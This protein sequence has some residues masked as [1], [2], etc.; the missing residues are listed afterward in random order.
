M[1]RLGVAAA[2]A[3]A[4]AAPL[5]A[6]QRLTGI[7]TTV[8][9]P[10]YEGWSFGDG[11]YQPIAGGDS[12]RIDRASQ[13]TIPIAVVFPLGSRF[14]LD[15]SAAYAMADVKLGE[16]DPELG[17]DSYSLSGLTDTKVRLTTKL[18]G[19]NVLFTLG[20]NGPTGK[21]ELDGE[22]LAALRV[23]AA[24][25]LAFSIPALGT[26]SGATAGLVFAR[27]VSSWALAFGASYEMRGE[28]SPVAL[29]GGVSTTDFNPSDAIHLSLGMNG[30][31]GQ[32]EMTLGVSGDFFGE[33]EIRSGTVSAP[34]TRL[35]PIYTFE[36][37]L[38]FAT[39]RLREASLF[40]IDRYRTNYEQDDQKIDESSGNYLD[41]G[42]R[43]IFPAGPRTGIITA[44]GVRHHTGLKV[45][46]TLSTAATATGALTVGLSREIGS[47]YMFQPFLRAQMGTVETGENSSDATAFGLGVTFSRRF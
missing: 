45:D 47:G 39:R 1:V 42:L 19:E 46:N 3:F 13:W 28:Y 6:Q 10:V 4:F 34:P 35:G 12:V 18:A 31:V 20:L 37:T 38:D 25:A 14:S 2:L 36:W 33:D 27:E 40:V 23:M 16:S 15:V 32:H 26:G 22:E 24:P 8:V 11:L 41:A 44:L 17:T 7:R 29:A 30:L 5:A 21:T 9:G 43:L